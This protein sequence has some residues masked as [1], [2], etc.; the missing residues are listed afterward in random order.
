MIRARIRVEGSWRSVVAFGAPMADCSG[1][2]ERDCGTGHG[3]RRSRTGMARVWRGRW[4]SG[5]RAPSGWEWNSSQSS[6]G[7]SELGFPGPA[8]G[9]MQGEAPRRAGEP[10]GDR[11]EPPPEGL[12]GHHLSPMPT[13]ADQRARLWAIT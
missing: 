8:L 7:A 1:C 11:E 3:K 6:Q 9:E 10:S 13:R 5:R 4:V 2:A 12:G